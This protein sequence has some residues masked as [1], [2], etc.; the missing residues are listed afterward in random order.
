MLSKSNNAMLNK[1]AARKKYH[2]I[3]TINFIA[4]DV[5][6]NLKALKELFFIKLKPTMILQT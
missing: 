6:N 1:V 4:L 2:L 3:K 5:T